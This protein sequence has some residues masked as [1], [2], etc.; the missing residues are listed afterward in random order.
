LVE[1]TAKLHIKLTL[2]LHKITAVRGN[3]V[4]LDTA[5]AQ[6]KNTVLNFYI[7]RSV[8]HFEMNAVP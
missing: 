6:H 8:E 7:S 4:S 1:I 3:F 5:L 2:S